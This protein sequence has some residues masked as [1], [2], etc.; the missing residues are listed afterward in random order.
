MFRIG[1]KVQLK[2]EHR[3]HPCGRWPTNLD[4]SDLCPRDTICTVNADDGHQQVV[5]PDVVDSSGNIV[6]EWNV[7]LDQWQL[8]APAGFWTIIYQ[9][10][11]GSSFS[12]YSGSPYSTYERAKEKADALASGNTGYHF[13][14]VQAFSEHWRE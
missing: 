7:H 3:A 2:P 9:S 6:G 5:F 11:L 13:F 4:G 14:V 10:R 8:A 12:V 1:D